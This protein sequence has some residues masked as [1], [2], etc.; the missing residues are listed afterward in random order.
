MNRNINDLL[1]ECLLWTIVLGVIILVICFIMLPGCAAS[2]G[3]VTDTGGG[4]AVSGASQA[5]GFNLSFVLGVA[6]AAGG[7]TLLGTICW[8]LYSV[9][10]SWMN[11]RYDR[12]NDQALIRAARHGCHKSVSRRRHR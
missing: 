4:G 8:Q 12:E 2:T 1:A 9:V 5:G 6:G 3:S 10:V 11:L 7:G